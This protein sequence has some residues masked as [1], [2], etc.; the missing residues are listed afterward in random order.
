VPIH[1]RLQR[2]LPLVR[3]VIAS[4]DD[5]TK[6][7][8][9]SLRAYGLDENV[10]DDMS[11]TRATGLTFAP[12]AGTQR[13]RNV[14]NKNVTEEQLLETAER[15]F[16]RGWTR[17]KLY[18]MIGLPTEEDEDV[19]GIVQTGVR[20][21]EV[22]RRV[23]KGR[24]ARV[25]VSVSTHVPKPHTP[26]QW[27]AMDP[28]PEVHRKQDMLRAEANAVRGLV[29]RMHAS[30]GSWI[31]GI[32]ARGDR[33]LA[34][35]IETAYE[36]GARFDSWDEQLRLDAWQ[37]ALAEHGVDPDLF[38][39]TLPTAARL[40]W[41]HID[42]GL[43]D[44]FL[45][46]E[47][48]RALKDRLSPPCGKPVGAFVHH[49]NAADAEADAR[50]LVCYHCGVACDLTRMREERIEFLHGLGAERPP[51][52]SPP[53]PEGKTQPRDRR[54]LAHRDQGPVRR[55]R[56]AYTRTGRN[57]YQGHLDV[58]RLLPRILRRARLPLYYTEGFHPKPG[59]TF[60]PA[61]PLGMTSFAEHLDLK[62]IDDGSQDLDADALL[63][64]L[65]GA[66]FDG[67]RFTGVRVLGPRDPAIQKVVDEAVYVAGLPQSTLHEHGMA[68][69]QALAARVAERRVGDLVIRRD[70]KGIGKRVDVA[71]YL[72][73]AQVG[74]GEDALA[75]AGITG[76]LVPVTLRLRVTQ[77]GTARPGEAL[78]TLLGADRVE[79]VHARWVRLAVY[80]H[81]DGARVVPLDLVS[82]QPPAAGGREA[83]VAT[84][85]PAPL[86]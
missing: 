57:T 30:D 27:C 13:M 5:S 80:A 33:R 42:V 44:G 43:E 84:A 86:P 37:G 11:K 12:E 67:I 21:L 29:L 60:G 63:E 83:V 1:R 24:R 52:P 20:A 66:T 26:F 59:M 65:Q 31:E 64:R 55:V 61:L 75:R 41:D 73:D 17:M 51:A 50:K 2:H 54:P 23:Q 45:A 58:V 16:S 77:Q 9:S 79:S 40:P 62:L 8:V 25:T 32:L 47:Y 4:L 19:R 56:L 48:R 70:V 74:E 38:L 39:G 46:R 72:L 35:V 34:A 6:V 18:F 10:L 36:R 76:G 78:A 53:R 49:T 15:V 14:V 68:D 81:R 22:A 69:A 28:Q 7:G 82:L 85:P 71:E 3:E